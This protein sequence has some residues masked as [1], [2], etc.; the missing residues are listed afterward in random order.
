MR[1]NLGNTGNNTKTRDQQN[2][3]RLVKKYWEEGREGGGGGG[4]RYKP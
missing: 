2:T 4:R 1:Y 3:V